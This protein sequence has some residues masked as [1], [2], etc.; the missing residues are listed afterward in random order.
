MSEMPVLRV[1]H[2]LHLQNEFIQM[3]FDFKHV[4]TDNIMHIRD[5]G[6]QLNYT[7]DINDPK[8]AADKLSVLF[9]IKMNKPDEMPVIDIMYCALLTKAPNGN[10]D[11]NAETY[12]S[13]DEGPLPV[14]NQIVKD[15]TEGLNISKIHDRFN[16]NN[17]NSQGQQEQKEINA[18]RNRL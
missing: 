5:Y 3:G 8:I 10:F 15:L 16:I 14:K 18:R 17:N 7:N 11:V 13:L 9:T 12:Y 6:I 4:D 1:E 2:V